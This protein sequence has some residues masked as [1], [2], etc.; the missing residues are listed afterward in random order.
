VQVIDHL[1]RQPLIPSPPRRGEYYQYLGKAPLKILALGLFT[2]SLGSIYGIWAVFS[3]A[4][5]WYVFLATLII[6]VPWSV[7][8]IVLQTFRPRVTWES[9][10]MVI[11]AGGYML[12]HSVDVFLPTCGE[13]PAVIRNTLYHILRMR[14]TG[15]FN[16][17]VLDDGDSSVIKDL[18]AGFHVHY[19]VRNDRPAWLKSGNMNNGLAHSNGE[20]IAVFDADFAPAPEFLTETVPYMLYSDLGI[21]QTAQYFDVRISETRNWVQQ[22]SGSIQDMFFCWAQPA[23]NSADAAMCVGTNVL[24]RRTAL[25]AT[26]GFPKVDGGEDVITGL[27]MYREG[28][29]TL[30]VPLA[31]AKGVCPDTFES[32]INQQYR[33]G[34]SSMMM[35]IPGNPHNEAFM[36]APL[37]LRQKMV[38]YS[39][40]LYYTQSILAL[41]LGVALSLVMFWDY[42]YAVRPGNYLPIAPALLGMFALPMIIRGWRP[43]VLRLIM[44]YSVAHLLA[45]VDVVRKT[46][47][48]W[49]PTGAKSKGKVPVTAGHV[50]R[51]WIVVTQGGMWIAL[52][53][54]VPLYGWANYYPAVLCTLFQT[55]ILLPLLLPGYG[56]IGQFTLL[57]HL[58]QKYRTYRKSIG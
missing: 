8:I 20:F 45:A 32:A 48:H 31:L 26:G 41:F 28:Y 50:L 21:L 9:H 14:W 35:F 54:D 6:M 47:G 3:R 42:P 1:Q 38:F 57:P 18:A 58:F 23:R 7:Y 24:Y 27:E 13:S 51:T 5:I 43:S 17:Y 25:E 30:Y 4:P 37:T 56:T 10:Q 2:L 52:F 29:R 36:K 15:P 19:L 55:V 40:A 46:G 39:G 22:L 33:W 34:R 53:R 49:V 44:V 12:K 16:V 11:Q